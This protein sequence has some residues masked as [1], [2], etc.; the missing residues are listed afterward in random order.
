MTEQKIKI[1]LVEDDQSLGYLMTDFLASK[2][3]EVTLCK[4]GISGWNS[5][6]NQPFQFAILDVM[7][8]GM[9]G[10]T[11]A[12]KI[13]GKQSDIPII[14]VTARSMKEDKINGFNLGVDDYIT[15]PFDE[16]ELY[17]RIQA[18]LNRIE[19]KPEGMMDQLP[20]GRYIYEYRN[21]CLSLQ[22]DCRRLTVRENE[23][24]L[25]LVQ[26]SGQIVKKEDILKKIWGTNDYF[27]GRSLDVYISKLRKY[28]Q[29]DP[30]I[31]IENISK[32]GFL[33]QIR[34]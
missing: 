2:G 31:L 19:P 11:L 23:V 21:Q 14:F 7:L 29:D 27:S 15:K 16:D 5:F 13:K 6:N 12:R 17:C 3:F 34:R 1:L 28:L 25:L 18:V 32:V 4:D 10:F 24:L 8:P 9:D 30:T 26:N 33:F 20:I 22:Q